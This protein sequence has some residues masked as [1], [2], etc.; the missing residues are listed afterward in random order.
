MCEMKGI[1]AAF[2]MYSKIPMPKIEW[3]AKNMRYAMAFF[4]LV[5]MVL[6]GVFLAWSR[7]AE[8]L[9]L[10]GVTFA[11]GSVLIPLLLTG[12]LHMDG[13]ID[14]VDAWHCYGGP[15]KRREVL[16]DPHVGAFGVIWCGAYLLALLGGWAQLYERPRFIWLVAA[17]FVFSRTLTAILTLT[18]PPASASGI[19]HSFASS[20]EKKPVIA[21]LIT[22]IALL[23][24]LG[25]WLELL[26]CGGLL[27]VIL[28]ISVLCIRAAKREFGG[29]SGDL[30]GFFLQIIE[31]VF[32][33]AAVIGGLI[34]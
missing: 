23:S 22:F 29:I 33:L 34:L 8:R 25:I 5:G 7:L 11:A 10:T 18:Q 3:N 2:A 15:E 32:L 19:L 20:T 1:I 30:A 26:V 16:K 13:F 9:E 28:L 14:T 6:G 21:I 12:G 17:G 24:A 4:P 31:L 27:A